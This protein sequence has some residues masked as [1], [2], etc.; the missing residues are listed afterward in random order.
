MEEKAHRTKAYRT[1]EKEKTYRALVLR[2]PL[3]TPLLEAHREKVVDLL[4]VQEEF[5][6]WAV[7]AGGRGELPRQNPLKYFA[8][9]LLHAGNALDWLRK[10][11]ARRMR[12]PLIFDAQ[13]RLRD[14]RDNSRGV[15]VD[16]QKAEVRIR[17]WSG[18]CGNTIVLPLAEK[19]AEWILA[20]VREGGGLAL[21]A[22]WVGASRRNRV[23]RLYVA[24]V[25]R[26]EAAPAF[27][28]RRLL[29]VD[30]NALHNGITWGVAERERILAKGV[31][32]PD[33]SR[34]MHIN[35][36]IAELDSLCAGRGDGVCRDAAAAKSRLWRLLRR[37]EDDAASKLIRLAI[38]Y[39]A[40]VVAD[41]P[42]NESMRRLKEGSYSAE[43]K[44]LLNFGRLRRRIQG[45]AEWHGV[46]YREER[47]Y[48]T[49]CPRC[50]SKMEELKNRRVRCRCGFSAH[51]DEV[52]IF[53]AQM[54][55]LF[56]SSFLVRPALLW[57][58]LPP[59][60]GVGP[61]PGAA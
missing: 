36:R 47:L 5:R 25:F 16:L 60:P 44:A 48:S 37:F 21:A 51:R 39:R 59:P 12:P 57:S 23:P 41:V 24:L 61:P 29:V 40:A 58:L 33:V 3:D 13:L 30:F 2:Y 50:G 52:P 9:K 1:E 42:N 8:Q 6:R 34:L 10:S 11:G 31:L 26:R 53:W 28:P 54:L 14:E 43:R 32:R 7:S 56:D 49:V 17:K 46:T 38:Q 27:Q 45:L 22:V 15:L 20:R 19:A 4:R 18:R 35:R 55:P